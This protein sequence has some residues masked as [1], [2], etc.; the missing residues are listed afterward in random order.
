MA[1]SL[2]P[3]AVAALEIHPRVERIEP[4]GLVYAD[5]T[6]AEE[7]SNAW[8]VERIG[9][10]AVHPG[11]MGDGIKVAVIDTGVNC[12]HPDLAGQCDGGYD[13]VND[14]NAPSDDNGH[15][16]HVAGTIAALRNMSGVVGV[17]PAVRIVPLKVLN[18]AGSG[19]FSDVIA[20]VQW[21]AGA[22]ARVT[23]NSYGSSQNPGS[24]VEQAFANAA[25]SDVLHIASAG[26]SGRCSGKGDTVGFPAQYTSVVAVAATNSSDGRPCFSSHGPTVEVAAPGVG[27][28]STVPGGYAYYSGTSM[29]S[30]HVAGVAALVMSA[31]IADTG[32]AAGVAD[33]VRA[34]LGA[35]AQDLGAAGRDSLFGYGLVDASAAVGAIVAPADAV[36]VQVATDKSTYVS[37]DADAQITVVVTDELGQPIDGI[38]PLMFETTVDGGAAAV[39]FT[40]QGN[41]VYTGTLGLGSL[42]SGP[43]AVA[44]QVTDAGVTG[45]GSA[46][47]SISQ[48]PS[49]DLSVSGIA[50]STSGGRNGDKHLAVTIEIQAG[51]Q[52]VGGA[53]VS[54]T[55]M[56]GGSAYASAT[57]TTDA[58]GLVTFSA[59]NAP[60]GTYSTIVTDVSAPGLTWDGVTPPNS[61]SK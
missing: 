28:L 45:S 21:A 3:Q 58:N 60:G 14:D 35:T 16:T 44:V 33:D 2:P 59:T 30:P 24:A 18:A 4:D 25:A 22:G 39:S 47:F 37:G 20:A 56:H 46:N 6:Y 19:T 42:G 61:F 40:G 57:G 7:L 29:A 32:G 26:N 9:A 48:A 13:F 15:G 36:N 50:Y 51:G 27:I 11:E 5:L 38:S 41:G 49:G 1:V 12:T 17:A 55:L 10:G 34:L 54:I 31:G 8:G 52:P 23:N 43:H 53:V